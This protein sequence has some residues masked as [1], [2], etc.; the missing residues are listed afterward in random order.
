MI[1]DDD[2]AAARI[3]RSWLAAGVAVCL[4]LSWL[5]GTAQADPSP[6]TTPSAAPSASDGSTPTDTSTSA[7]PAPSASASSEPASSSPSDSPSASA[8]ASSV[9]STSTSPSASAAPSTSTSPSA[10][11]SASASGSSA[12]ADAGASTRAK[13]PQARAA[14]EPRFT[15]DNSPVRLRWLS[16]GGAQGEVGALTS[17]EKII[18]AGLEGRFVGADILAATGTGAAYELHGAIRSR[19]RSFGGPTST[20]GF[21]TSDQQDIAEISGA[22]RNLFTSGAILWSGPTGAYAVDRAF[23]ARFRSLSTPYV[24][25][26]LPTAAQKSGAASGS[27]K[28]VFTHGTLLWTRATGTHVVRGGIRTRYESLGGE[29]VLGVPLTDE[30]A[31]GKDVRQKFRLGTITWVASTGATTVDA[32]YKPYLTGVDTAVNALAVIPVKGYV[33]PR[34]GGVAVDL[35]VY[36]SGAYSHWKRFTTRSDGSF[37]GTFDYAHSELTTFSVRAAALG[38]SNTWSY[39]TSYSIT[40]ESWQAATV[41]SVTSADVRYSYRSGCPVGP[42]QLRVIEMNYYGFDSKMHRGMMIVRQDKVDDVKNIFWHAMDKRFPI[43]KMLNPDAYKGSDPAMMEADNTSGFNCRHVTGNPYRMSPHS[44]G[45]AFDVNTVENPYFDGSKWWPA[46]GKAYIQGGSYNRSPLKRGSLASYSTLTDR[47]KK[48][49][50]FWGG[51]WSPGR[52]WQ[53]FEER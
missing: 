45:Y 47:A 20:L 15:R 46:N 10:S 4:A 17:D 42:S 27:Q 19:Y 34:I 51:A 36:R 12:S 44:Y 22:R 53:H 18:G 52:D 35:Q 41:R 48:R 38:T 14:Q 25:L 6:S 29:K 30:Y 11:P 32:K 37:S 49:G 21:P 7:S 39:G 28:Q 1:K 5:P 31:V 43:K 33:V 23:W 9:P 50:W 13:T 26:G 8:S 2:R 16:L 24:T 3:G 40:R